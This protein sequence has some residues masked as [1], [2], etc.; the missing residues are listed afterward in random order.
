MGTFTYN[1]SDVQENEGVGPVGRRSQQAHSS[2]LIP[3]DRLSL[4]ATKEGLARSSKHLNLMPGVSRFLHVL[5]CLLS[6]L[7]NPGP[8]SPL[9][10]LAWTALPNKEAKDKH[11]S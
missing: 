8:L 5:A 7:P 3:R 6:L 11:L 4:N 9:A 1:R 10:S 2:Q